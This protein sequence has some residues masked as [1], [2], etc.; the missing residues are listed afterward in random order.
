MS[1][2]IKSNIDA[3][4]KR[5][6]LPVEE[7]LPAWTL[8][9]EFFNNIIILLNYLEDSLKDFSNP[10]YAQVAEFYK[11]IYFKYK[12]IDLLT[13]DEIKA[14]MKENGYGLLLET[15]D[16]DLDKLK[17]L[18]I[19][20][21]LF[22]LLKG[23]D[24]GYRLLL[25]VIAYDFEI[26]TWLDNPQELDEY[27]YNITYITFLNTGFGSEII[28]NFI[29]LSRFYVYPILKRITIRVIYRDEQ[30]YVHG[31]PIIK[32][33]MKVKCLTELQQ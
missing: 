8:K 19:Y 14:I 29:K 1:N 30:P 31:L 7:Y 4:D 12:N 20:L 15:L 17:T 13:E 24:E 25:K 32:K 23:T 11:D 10:K 27:T 21:P 18:V 33:S 2:I 22:K 5:T 9:T 3:S 16:M 28:N 26:E 6:F